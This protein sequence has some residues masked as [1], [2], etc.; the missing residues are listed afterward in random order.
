MI[1]LFNNP[2]NA[3]NDED[4]ILQNQKA[5]YSNTKDV[6]I[7]IN[8]EQEQEQDEGILDLTLDSTLS[9]MLDEMELTSDKSNNTNDIVQTDEPSNIIEEI[10]DE[11]LKSLENEYLDKS[12]VKEVSHS[13]LD[14]LKFNYEK[15]DISLVMEDDLKNSY[16]FFFI[17]GKLQKVQVE[18]I[19]NN[20]FVKRGDI[21]IRYKNKDLLLTICSIQPTPENVKNLLRTLNNNLYYVKN[22]N[23]VKQVNP[24]DFIQNA[25]LDIE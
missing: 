10:D 17:K 23:D 2:N 19:L 13:H 14:L 24:L 5:F 11:Y 8:E 1:D 7:P 3:D 6:N 12:K 15:G 16:P 20:K 25:V 21:P 22:S 4:L 18:N 9:S